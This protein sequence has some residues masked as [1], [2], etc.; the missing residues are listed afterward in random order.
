[1]TD[2]QTPTTN[3]LAAGWLFAFGMTVTLICCGLGVFRGGWWWAAAIAAGIATA[4]FG[5]RA[6]NV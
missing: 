3:E 5:W 6:G 4:I 2:D 1:M